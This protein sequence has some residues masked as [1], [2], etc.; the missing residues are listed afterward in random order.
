MG[1]FSFEWFVNEEAC[2]RRPL[3][4]GTA[5]VAARASA[6]GEFLSA[7]SDATGSIRKGVDFCAIA[8]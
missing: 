7:G 4:V 8:G 6:R 3:G 1:P 5:G 2:A